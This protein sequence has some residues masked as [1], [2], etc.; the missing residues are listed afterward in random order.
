MNSSDSFTAHFHSP[1][2][3]LFH[4]F[5]LLV[6]NFRPNFSQRVGRMCLVGETVESPRRVCR[7]VGFPHPKPALRVGTDLLPG[8]G[9]GGLGDKEQCSCSGGWTSCPPV[10]WSILQ[11][12]RKEGLL[13]T[14][15]Q[16]CVS[17]LVPRCAPRLHLCY[18]KDEA[19]RSSSIFWF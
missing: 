4:P 6:L 10:V 14:C 5:C 11:M 12:D 7:A 8:L 3:T 19:R 18:G 9:A 1:Y 2:S 16:C 13:V 15:Q 17:E